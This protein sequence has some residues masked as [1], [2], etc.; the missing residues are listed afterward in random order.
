[1]HVNKKCSYIIKVIVIFFL[2]IFQIPGGSRNGGGGGE[3][4]EG[5]GGE[6]VFSG[7]LIMVYK[8]KS[9]A[10][11]PP[12]G[13]KCLFDVYM[14]YKIVSLEVGRGSNPTHPG[15]MRDNNIFLE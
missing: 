5:G 11:V 9:D 2:F 10:E 1:M 8:T 7:G 14:H 12:S 13:I 6:L 4:R 15:F 3:G